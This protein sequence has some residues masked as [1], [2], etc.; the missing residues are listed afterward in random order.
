MWVKTNTASTKW[1]L[2]LQS[3]GWCYEEAD[4]LARSL[5]SLG[6]SDLMGTTASVSGI[7]SED[8]TVNPDFYNWNHVYFAYCDGASFAGQRADTITYEGSQL[9]FRGRNI[10]DASFAELS[11]KFQFS[12]A[13]DVFFTGSSAGGLGLLMHADY[14]KSILPK[15]VTTYKTADLSGFFLNHNNVE[16]KAVYPDQMKYVWSMQNL[17]ASA[18]PSC[19]SSKSP[20]NQW[21]CAFAAENYPFV[22]APIFVSNSAIDWW[23]VTC[24]LTAE[25]VPLNSPSNGNC[26]AAP[27]W[28]SCS[29]HLLSCTPDQV[30]VY[31]DYG[32]TFL[33]TINST[34]VFTKDGNGAFISSCFTHGYEIY[35]YSWQSVTI[36]G[37]TMRDAFSKWW[38]SESTTPASQ[39]TH[40]PCTYSLSDPPNYQ[41][42]PTCKDQ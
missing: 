42:N 34:Y 9:F 40:L 22:E 4:C 29:N 30:Q 26:S 5:T 11:K 8:S 31:M 10:L 32:D 20:E 14:V 25:P 19:L 18:N 41:C 37:V 39:N 7:M 38:Y 6:S 15:T 35:T 33:Q 3:G 27:G 1:L 16:E 21:L 23:Q 28:N 36:D 24:I 17:S 12:T 2:M 13:T